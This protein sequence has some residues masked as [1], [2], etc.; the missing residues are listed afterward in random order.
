VLVCNVVIPDLALFIFDFS[1]V[2]AIARLLKI[3]LVTQKLGSK[4]FILDVLHHKRLL[5]SLDRVPIQLL[6]V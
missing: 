3:G 1:G 4:A 6:L 5:N 2:S